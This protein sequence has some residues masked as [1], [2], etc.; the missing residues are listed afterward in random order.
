MRNGTY[1]PNLVTTHLRE[2]DLSW[3]WRASWKL[4]PHPMV[5]GIAGR[6]RKFDVREESVLIR[7]SETLRSALNQALLQ[8]FP[9]RMRCW[10]QRI[11]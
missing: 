4:A 5:P 8:H 2:R 1:G 11:L 9:L 7:D 6:R 10:A 3:E